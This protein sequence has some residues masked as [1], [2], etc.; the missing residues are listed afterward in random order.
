M[1]LNHYVILGSDSYH[2]IQLFGD[3]HGLAFTS[4]TKAEKVEKQMQEERP[5]L[6]FMT[7]TIDP[8]PIEEDCEE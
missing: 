6:D 1:A 3:G 5:G 4:R 7:M 8:N 2:R